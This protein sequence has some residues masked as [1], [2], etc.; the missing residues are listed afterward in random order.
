MKHIALLLP[1]VIA[2]LLSGCG[3]QEEKKADQEV[4]TPV[5][6]EPAVRGAIDHLV[7]ADAV[8]YPINQ[9]N[10]TS[11]ISAPVKRILVNRGDHVRAG[12]LLAELESRDLA[13]AASEG[14]EQYESAQA[15]YQ[16]TTGATLPE[17]KTKAQADVQAAAQALDAAKKL[18]DNRVAL[19]KEGALAQKLVDDAKVAMVQAQSTFETAQRHLQAINQVSQRET[20]RGAEAQ[21]KAAKAHY[22]SASV[23]LGYAEVRSPI[24]GIV[25]DRPLYPGEMAASGSPIISIVDIS[26]VIARANVPVKEA[27]SIQVGRSARISGPDGDIPAKVTVVSPSVDLNTTTVEVWVQAANPGEKLKPGGSVRVNIIAETIQDTI[28][29]PASALLNSDEGGQKVMVVG[30]DSRAQE[31]K[32][33]VG[34][35]QGNRVQIVTGLQAGDQVVTSGGL[36]LEDKAK[37]AVQKAPAE[38]EES[39]DEK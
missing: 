12:Q 24:N 27:G 6:A 14:K 25:S 15:A 4:P 18:Y 3:K 34:V 38:E 35:R 20:A 21:M 30:A 10:I 32:V 39:A 17:D 19:Q 5:T 31:R 23:M 13:A 2:M 28:I 11:K 26:Q 8:L 16:T 9:A 29:V 1:I 7:T 37:V 36:G 22:E 33:S